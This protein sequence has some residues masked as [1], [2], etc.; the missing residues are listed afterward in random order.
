MWLSNSKQT[1]T[2]HN[3]RRFQ[4]FR[5]T[6]AHYTTRHGNFAALHK[7]LHGFTTLTP[8]LLQHPAKPTAGVSQDN[9]FQMKQAN[10]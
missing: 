8:S 10:K 4:H 2:T 3:N 5:H 9:T 6:P 1:F 7:I